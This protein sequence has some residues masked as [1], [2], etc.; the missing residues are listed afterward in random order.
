[1]NCPLRRG[2]TAGSGQARIDDDA[3]HRGL[4]SLVKHFRA[5]KE[6]LGDLDAEAAATLIAAAADIA[7][8][9]DAQGMIRMWPSVATSCRPNGR[10]KWLGRPWTETVTVESRP[11][12]EAMLRDATAQAP[13]RWRHLN[14]PSADGPDVPILYSAVKVG[15]G[16]QSGRGRPRPAGHGCPAAALDRRAAVDGARLFA[17]APC[18]DP[19]PPAVPGHLRGRD[20]R[21][22]RPR[23]RWWRPTPRRGSCSARACG[24]S[25][26]D[27]FP[28]GSTVESRPRCARC[29]PVS[30]RPAVPTMSARM[31][32]EG[33]R[34]LLVSASLFRQESASL[35]LVRL[36]PLDAD[37]G[38]V[39]AAKA[40]STLLSLVEN[41][42]GRVRRHQPGWADPTANAAFLDLA[43]IADRGAGAGR[44]AG[45]LARAARG[46]PQRADRQPTPARLGTAVR[47]HLRGE[48]GATVEIEVSAVSMPNGERALFRVHH[49]QCR[50]A[51]HLRHARRPPAA[52]LGRAD[53]RAGRPGA[54][55]GPGARDHRR[56]RA[57]VHRGSARADRR[58]PRLRRR[59]SGAEPAEPLR[60]AAALRAGRSRSD[61]TTTNSRSAG[62]AGTAR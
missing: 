20:D 3:S 18:R 9:V 54:V 15:A 31:L 37:A 38:A 55:E 26:G 48:Y 43:Q 50:P 16:R 59:D 7:L 14:H 35:F 42:P 30:G 10:R 25:S 51:P 57:A 29:W 33:R 46:R 28:K 5:P 44:I 23:T 32:S 45:A 62:M 52:A 12:V 61:A 1:M 21:R 19:L 11:K 2:S 60:Q 36:I 13:P 47:H 17:S 41:A 6:S 27:R 24:G 34:E 58:Q 8:I 39:V 40:K 22:R 49:P 56:D 4:Q 53:D